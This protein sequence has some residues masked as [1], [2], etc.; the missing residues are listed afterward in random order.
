MAIFIPGMECH[1][2]GNEIESGEEAVLFPSFI[3]NSLDP[4]IVFNDSVM[5]SECFSNHPDNKK[6][7]NL[8]KQRECKFSPKNRICDL[9]HNEIT[10][11][12]DYEA[13]P[14]LSSRDDD[15][16]GY[17]FKMYHKKCLTNSITE[18]N[19]KEMVNILELEGMWASKQ[20]F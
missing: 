7:T 4:L 20:K 10:D 11:P 3:A 9:C 18:R 12:D 19:I 1:V 8:L 2:C 13:H 5:H 16:S 14:C 6:V 15:L 17:N